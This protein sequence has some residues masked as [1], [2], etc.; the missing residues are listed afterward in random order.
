M[1]PTW[2]AIVGLQLALLCPT[3][4][5]SVFLIAWWAVLLGGRVVHVGSRV[6]RFLGCPAHVLR[7]W[8]HGSITPLLVGQRVP[9]LW[10][11]PK[12]WGLGSGRASAPAVACL[13][14]SS[15][16]VSGW[17][18]V[19]AH[20]WLLAGRICGSP[21]GVALDSSSQGLG[22]LWVLSCHWGMMQR[23]SKPTL[24]H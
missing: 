3:L 7:R 17:N 9:A 2:V 4:G 10:M 14:V 23:Q 16:L 5:V 11:L 15:A 13:P 24:K 22:A 19:M 6:H 20:G 8:G 21:L 12:L 1:V 18:P